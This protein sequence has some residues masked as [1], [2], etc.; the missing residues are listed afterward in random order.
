MKSVLRKQLSLTTVILKFI[1][2]SSFSSFN[3]RIILFSS[4]C[5]FIVQN[6]LNFKGTDY[7]S[8]DYEV[9]QIILYGLKIVHKLSQ[10]EELQSSVQFVYGK[11]II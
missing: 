11:L 2:D 9:G 7:P 1:Y 4:Q 5:I 6:S 3:P 8:Y 10:I